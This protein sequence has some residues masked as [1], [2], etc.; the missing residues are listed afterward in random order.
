MI[1]GLVSGHGFS[2]AETRAKKIWPLGPGVK[3]K[4]PA[5]L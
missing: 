3:A 5:S 1:Q 4:D 2:R